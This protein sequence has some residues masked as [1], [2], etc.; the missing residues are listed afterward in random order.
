MTAGGS[1]SRACRR[2]W[3]PAGTPSP[4]STSRSTSAPARE[5]PMSSGLGIWRLPVA[6]AGP[7]VG[8]QAAV[9]LVGQAPLEG[10][11]G[12]LL[13]VLLL[14]AVVEVGTTQPAASG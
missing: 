4:A 6:Q 3:S 10:T 9:D 14:E 5:A 7:L 13:G 2:T 1:C 8:Q 12:L 11:H